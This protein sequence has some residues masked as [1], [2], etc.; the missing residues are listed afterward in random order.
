MG[1]RGIRPPRTK[2][3]DEPQLIVGVNDIIASAKTDGH[4]ANNVTDIKAIINAKGIEIK[5][6]KDMPPSESGRLEKIGDKWTI[7]VN[8]NHHPNRQKFTMAHE[9]AHYVLHRDSSSAFQ[10]TTF[11]RDEAYTPIE[12]AANEFA[13]QLLMP[14]EY[15]R[16][17]I[18]DG[19][20]SIRGLA[21][22]FEVSIDAMKNRIKSLG[23]KTKASE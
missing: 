20:K 5:Y 8:D 10:D 13:S 23:Y 22:A 17:C 3:N 16:S 7:T 21:E 15:V 12:F 1:V 11:F 2:T 18:N 4:I 6:S 14:E 19:T 9:L